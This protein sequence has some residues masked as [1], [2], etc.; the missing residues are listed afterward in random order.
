MADEKPPRRKIKK[1]RIALLA[2]S[3]ILCALESAAWWSIWHGKGFCYT[4]QDNT[5][6]GVHVFSSG[7]RFIYATGRTENIYGWESISYHW[8]SKIFNPSSGNF[9]L[10]ETE[11]NVVRVSG[12]EQWEAPPGVGPCR[13]KALWIAHW[14]V[15]W[16]TLAYP[17]YLLLQL[18]RKHWTRLKAYNNDTC[19]KCGYDIRASKERCPECGTPVDW[20]ARRKTFQPKMNPP[21]T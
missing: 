5:C 15:F 19:L 7:Y 8:T 16:L 18:A 13:I 17:I 20:P 11:S 4:Y 14:P 1:L 6:I 12:Y 9:L 3:L 2:I 10:Y 21:K